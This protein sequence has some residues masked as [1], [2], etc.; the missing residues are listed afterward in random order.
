MH[1][2][3]TLPQKN[4]TDIMGISAD[5]RDKKKKTQ[6]MEKFWKCLD[7]YSAYTSF[8]EASSRYKRSKECSLRMTS[9]YGCQ[10]TNECAVA[11]MQRKV[12]PKSTRRRGHLQR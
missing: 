2:R 7:M 1:C 4:R 5:N 3:K 8:R 6:T 9:P 10:N 12:S 11:Y